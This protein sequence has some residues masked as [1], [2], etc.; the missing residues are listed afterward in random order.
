MLRR[1]L[2][3]PA[4][5]TAL[6]LG[7]VLTGVGYWTGRTIVSAVSDHLVREAVDGV[8][9]DVAELVDRPPK[10]LSRLAAAITQ[11]GVPLDDPHAVLREL[12][13][14]LNNQSSVDWLFFGNEAGGDVAAGRRRTSLPDD[15]WVSPRRHAPV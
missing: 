6:V 2:I 9:R 3:L 12:Y 13:F 10:V 7:V 8:V 11:H 1:R 4:A 15:G 14:A 5:A